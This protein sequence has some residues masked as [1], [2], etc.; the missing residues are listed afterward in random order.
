LYD[1]QGYGGGIPTHLHVEVLNSQLKINSIHS[2]GV[3]CI[4]STASSSSSVAR[5]HVAVGSGADCIKNTES[6][7]VAMLFP[8]NERFF[9]LQNSCFEQI[10]HNN[11]S[12]IISISTQIS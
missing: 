2:L 11:G 6:H 12:E 5:I 1:L 3:D 7:D 8:S 10:C 9:W 4:E